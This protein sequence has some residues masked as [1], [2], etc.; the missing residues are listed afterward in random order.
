MRAEAPKR[1]SLLGFA[2]LA[3]LLLLQRRS[4]G[5]SA[6]SR[7]EALRWVTGN[8]AGRGASDHLICIP[9]GGVFLCL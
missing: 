8:A 9:P 3:R 1:G 2:V 4:S 6:G 7:L 5:T